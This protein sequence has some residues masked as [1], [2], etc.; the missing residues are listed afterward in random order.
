MS[1][2]TLTP[3][4]ERWLLLTLA[5]IQFT[6][7]LDFM[8]MMPLGPQFT[9]LFDISDAQ[10][11][12]LVS[13]YTFSAGASGLAASAYLD[14]FDRKRLLVVL[15]TL[16][17]LSTM[18]CALAMTYGQFFVARV[19]AGLFGGVLSALIQ[20]ILADVVP[21]ERRGRAMGVVM[22]SFSVSTVAGVP[23]GLYLAAAF[24]WHA[25]FW[26]VVGLCGVFGAM[27]YWTVP[28][29][30]A[31]LDHPDRHSVWGEIVATVQERNHQWSFAF[32]MVSILTGF[33]IIPYITI[34]LET[35]LAVSNRD[36]PLLY[37]AGGAATLVSARWIGVLSDR[38]GKRYMYE[39]LAA[40]VGI[41]LFTLTLMPP[42]P[43]WVLTLVYVL[44]FVI[45][46][47]RMIPSMAVVS[48]A[49]NPRRRGTFMAISGALQS[50][51][52]G[53]AA[54]VGGL[55]IG[56]SADGQVT[57]YW[58]T[59][60]LGTLAS[61]ASVWLIRRIQ[62]PEGKGPISAPKIDT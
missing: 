12:A 45:V 3:Q 10:F 55:L 58:I 11:G 13:A 49:A 9:R 22:S 2:T 16:F 41:P 48:A 17:A 28:Q 56:R 51:A 46:S 29:L 47:G 6:Y 36:I 35:N 40:L 24:S 19:G 20:T 32:T 57:G 8:V 30:R 50:F 62:V 33:M 61:F 37:L 52:M 4:R 44:F 53:L 25:P 5:G 60:L 43:F 34:Y 26:L 1:H 14:R 21:F 27:A 59:A 38:L 31:H 7:I 54:L 18:G 39:R 15:Y 42:A 23:L